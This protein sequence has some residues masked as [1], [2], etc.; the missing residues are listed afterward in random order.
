MCR[1]FIKKHHPRYHNGSKSRNSV[2]LR[3]GI[4]LGTLATA[5]LSGIPLPSTHHN[6]SK[7]CDSLPLRNGIFLGILATA[8]L[9]GI[10][11]SSPYHNGSKSRDSLPLRKKKDADSARC[12]EREFRQLAI[13]RDGSAEWRGA[14]YRCQEWWRI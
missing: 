5:L 13:R 6:G 2:P 4:F 14:S 10:P 11:S 9:S 1:K 12:P 8:L 3:N 7:T